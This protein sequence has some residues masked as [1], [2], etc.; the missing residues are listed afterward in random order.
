MEQLELILKDDL[1]KLIPAIIEWNNSELMSQVKEIL[2]K[3]ENAV[4]IDGNIF[5]AK[6]DRAKLNAFIKALNNE[7]LSIKKRYC[8]PLNRFTDEV[9]EVIAAVQ[10]VADKIGDTITAYEATRKEEK[11]SNIIAYFNER[12]GDL[13]SVISYEKIEDIKWYNNSLKLKAIFVDIDAKISKIKEDLSV[14]ESLGE[15]DVDALKLFYFRTL[16]LSDALQENKRLKA[17]KIKIAELNT[18][19]S[20]QLVEAIEPIKEE[21]FI[22]RFEVIGTYTEL[23]N[24]KSFLRKNNIKYKAVKEN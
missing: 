21:E 22:I 24:L 7:R 14:I 9:N 18:K 10:S 6:E 20:I 3:Y 13:L 12:I 8:A 1:E 15:D 11:K 19:S 2:P 17:E 4:Y 16:N 23:E 5:Q